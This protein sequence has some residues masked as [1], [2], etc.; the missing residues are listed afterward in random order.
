MWEMAQYEI[1][2][3]GGEQAAFRIDA[4]GTQGY[5]IGR[6][7]EGSEYTPDID[8]TYFNARD[9]GV[10]RRHVALVRYRGVTHIVDLHSVNGTYVNGKRLQ[11]DIPHPLNS[12]DEI[13][14]GNLEMTFIQVG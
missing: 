1:R 11:S 8:L 6:S 12:G 10:S 14:L 7:D 4:P 13:R 2:V 5:I 3:L 9:K